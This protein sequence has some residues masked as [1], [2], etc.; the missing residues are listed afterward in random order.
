MERKMY[1]VIE[2]YGDSEPWWFLEDWEK[3]SSV[4]ATLMITMKP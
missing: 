2:M 3:T 1:Q 4:V